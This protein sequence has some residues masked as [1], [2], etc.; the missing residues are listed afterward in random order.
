[1]KRYSSGSFAPGL[2]RLVDSQFGFFLLC[3]L[4]WLTYTHAI[5]LLFFSIFF[6]Q[7][8]FSS[9]HFM[10]VHIQFFVCRFLSLS[11]LPAL[12]PSPSPQIHTL[13]LIHTNTFD[14][15]S[16]GFFFASPIQFLLAFTRLNVL[17]LFLPAIFLS[18]FYYCYFYY[19]YYCKEFSHACTLAN[20]RK[21]IKATNCNRGKKERKKNK[22]T[23]FHA[24][25]QCC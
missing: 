13:R 3:R 12:V 20:N 4:K 19:L 2:I 1:M 24:S 23:K 8:V 10:L 9:F 18:S 16:C 22:R 7:L 5:F 6:P 15:L 21:K 25:A 17:P 14:S 11:L